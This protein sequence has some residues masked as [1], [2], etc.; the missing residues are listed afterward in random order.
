MKEEEEEE[1]AVIIILS[2]RHRACHSSV[3]LP[4]VSLLYEAGG[5]I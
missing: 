1:E 5:D 4:C 2:V 3:L